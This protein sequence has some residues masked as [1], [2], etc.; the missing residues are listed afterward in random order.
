M[1]GTLEV[2]DSCCVRLVNEKKEV[3]V[4]VQNVREGKSKEVKVCD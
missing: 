2:R 3:M 1:V 4:A